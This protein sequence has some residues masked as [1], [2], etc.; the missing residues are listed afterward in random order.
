MRKLIPI[1]VLILI[2]FTG[3][4]LFSSGLRESGKLGMAQQE[5]GTAVEGVVAKAYN[6]DL[7]T[8]DQFVRFLAVDKEVIAAQKTFRTI[9]LAAYDANANFEAV[10]A[11][12]ANL[13]AKIAVG[14]TAVR[15]F[16]IR[17]DQAV[18]RDLA[19]GK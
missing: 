16:G 15:E 4:A 7:I 13:F 12:K 1:S 9:W 6:R 18:L 2:L 3:C 19:E 11:A 10:I 8:K 17:L 14:L 5:G